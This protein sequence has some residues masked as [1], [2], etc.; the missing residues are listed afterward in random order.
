MMSERQAIGQLPEHLANVFD[1]PPDEVVV[2]T[3]AE[4]LD[5]AAEVAGVRLDV[6][7]KSRS[8]A[9]SVLAG[10]RTLS[11]A[12]VEG[13]P[14][15][16]VPFMGETGASLCREERVSWLDLSG[17]AHI[18]VPGARIILRGFPNKFVS[19]G[20]P[21]NVFASKSARVTRE[22]LERVPAPTPQADLAKATDL[23]SGF[24]S[25]I[26]RRL[27]DDRLVL[28]K[29]GDI[30]V[31]DPDALLTAWSERY[32]F[33][34]HRIRKGHMTADSSLELVHKLEQAMTSRDIEHAF[35]GLASAWLRDE[36]ARFRLVT[37]YAQPLPTSEVLEALRFREGSRGAN[38]WFIEPNDST[39]F[40]HVE[41]VQ[42]VPCVSVIQT[43][44]DLLDLPERA[45]EAAEHLRERHLRWGSA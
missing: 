24:V 10:L 43:Y 42:G 34:K 13:H 40:N 15:L 29:N 11:G 44:L 30:S 45:E 38:V 16:V 25:R 36:H 9:A 8:D 23:G 21:S 2:L 39:L 27:I 12:R 7:Y 26:V 6:E 17:N 20:R 3:T 4:H 32:D 31:P 33:H 18:L 37:V 1:V 22:L 5:F 41:R 19:A 14:L 28:R 35:T